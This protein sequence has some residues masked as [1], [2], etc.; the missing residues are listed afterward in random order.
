MKIKQSIFKDQNAGKIITEFV[1]LRST[2]YF[3]TF[4]LFLA[5]AISVNKNVTK[6][7]K[8][9]YQFNENAEYNIYS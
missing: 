6:I 9:E 5:K 8:M 4:K 2:V 7:F 3:L 1:G